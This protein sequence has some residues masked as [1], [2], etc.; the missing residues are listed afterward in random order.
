MSTGVNSGGKSGYKNEFTFDVHVEY[1]VRRGGPWS[2]TD[3]NVRYIAF[4][5]K[6]TGGNIETVVI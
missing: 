6:E 1:T 5:T 3:D 2:A 4:E